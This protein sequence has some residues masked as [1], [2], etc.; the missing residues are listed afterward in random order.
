ML[1]RS[2]IL[3]AAC[4]SCSEVLKKMGPDNGNNLKQQRFRHKEIVRNRLPKEF[5][6]SPPLEVFK[7]RLDIVLSNLL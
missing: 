3:T 1:G 7:T 5:M 2:R 6:S 4:R